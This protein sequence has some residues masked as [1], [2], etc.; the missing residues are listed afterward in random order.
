MTSPET[1]NS[2]SEQV[3]MKISAVFTLSGHVEA[4]MK[5][6]IGQATQ[7]EVVVVKSFPP[8]YDIF[9][10]EQNVRGLKQTL[11]INHV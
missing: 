9:E 6:R 11:E 1:S 3:S 5:H 4:T 8:K 10:L 7:L 2:E